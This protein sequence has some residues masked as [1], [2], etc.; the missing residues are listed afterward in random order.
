MRQRSTSNA[1]RS[2]SNADPSGV[3]RWALGVGRWTLSARLREVRQSRQM[4]LDG[5]ARA[6]GC[7]KAY[8]S[9]IENGRVVN[10]PSAR[11]LGAVEEALGIG[12][13]S[14]RKLA[15]W[16][17][18]PQTVKD[19]LAGRGPDLAP[20]EFPLR[21]APLINRVAAGPVAEFTD[22]DY[23]VDVA[24]EYVPSPLA[25]EPNAFAARVVGDSMA[26]EYRE[27]EIVLFSPNREVVDGADCFVRLL[28]D[29][30][31]TFK[32]VFFEEGGRV[33]LQP[34]NGDYPAQSVELDQVTALWPAVMRIV[35]INP[36]GAAGQEASRQGIQEQ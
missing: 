24:D 4:T 29:Q 35:P 26:P 32:R 33:R 22:L 27:G 20:L 2:T 14:L 30:V 7:S 12:D 28:P 31:T 17:S 19:A 36:G 1:Q 8:L 16:E 10:P 34:L 15:D 11:I 6:V 13:G 9:M 21:P 23:P 5:L 25:G 3:G 18:T